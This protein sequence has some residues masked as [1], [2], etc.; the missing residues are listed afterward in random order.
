MWE[1]GSIDI[2]DISFIQI[3]K[4]PLKKVSYNYD[5]KLNNAKLRNLRTGYQ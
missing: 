1:T 5:F 2:F 3:Y 4:N